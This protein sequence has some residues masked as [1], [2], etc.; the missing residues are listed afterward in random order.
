MWRRPKPASASS[1]ADLDAS[2]AQHHRGEYLARD[3]HERHLRI[4]RALIRHAHVSLKGRPA[5]RAPGHTPRVIRLRLAHMAGR[6]IPPPS[7]LTRKRSPAAKP[8]KSGAG[9]LPGP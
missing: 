9:T 4:R 6:G 5:R 8:G 1:S 7:P 2:L 3:F